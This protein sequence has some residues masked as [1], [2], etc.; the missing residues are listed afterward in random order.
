MRNDTGQVDLTRMKPASRGSP[1]LWRVGPGRVRR[2]SKF[3]GSGRVGSGGFQ[4]LAGRVGS[5]Q[6]V[7]KFSRVGS[8]RVKTS[9]TS[10]VSG[11]YNS[12]L[13]FLVPFPRSGIDARKGV[14]C[15]WATFTITGCGTA[16]SAPVLTSKILAGSTKCTALSLFDAPP[17]SV[18]TSITSAFPVASCEEDIPAYWYMRLNYQ[19]LRGS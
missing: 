12:L 15:K 11:R 10:H 13:S 3:C 17:S 4:N 16:N 2:I 5:G 7:S 1:E 9:R 14:H 6:D 19:N 18:S 8:G